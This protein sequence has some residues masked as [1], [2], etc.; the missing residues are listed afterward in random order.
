MADLALVVGVGADADNEELERL[1]D[2]LRG[3]LLQLEVD[4]VRRPQAGEAPPGAKV[5]GVLAIG[6][7]IVELARSSAV[8]TAVVGAVQSWVGSRRDRSVK[9][10]LDGDSIEVTGISPSD[11]RK[12]ID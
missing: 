6:A 9:L 4:S 11:Q 5:G 12:L 10:Q 8:L 1:T 7:L 3:E 2:Q